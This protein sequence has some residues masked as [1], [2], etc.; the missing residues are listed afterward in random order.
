MMPEGRRQWNADAK[1]RSAISAFAARALALGEPDLQNR[2]F[3]A[4]LCDLG[5]GQIVL[6]PI[7]VGPPVLDSNGNAIYYPGGRASVPID[8]AGCQ[9]GTPIG[10]VHSHPGVNAGV[11]S[12]PD[13]GYGQWHVDH[14]GAP[15]TFGIYVISDYQ[16][17]Q[18]GNY[19]T[20]VTRSGLGDRQAANSGTLV[21][22]WV[23]PDAEPCPGDS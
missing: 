16:D 8:P 15:A 10:Y 6:G 22:N 17:P 20:R 11:P 23:N 18:T 19:S 5:N 7:E 9:S 13:F 1:A 12:D 3:G 21:P 14:N 4:L 2:E